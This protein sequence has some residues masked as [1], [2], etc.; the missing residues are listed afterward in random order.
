MTLAKA[1]TAICGTH[2]TSGV[3]QENIDKAYRRTIVVPV[4]AATATNAQGASE[5][6]ITPGVAHRLVAAKY[7][8]NGTTL[9]T[10]AVNSATLELT[11]M[12]TDGSTTTL[13]GSLGNTAAAITN[14]IAKALTM[15]ATAADGNAS[16]SY[17]VRW[18]KGDIT[19]TGLAVSKGTLTL[20]FEEID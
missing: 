19:T 14:A 16:E 13:V 7:L 3:T 9:S 5:S 1:K 12:A 18:V 2:L 8:L 15:I 20:I 4:S 10:A 6:V 17:Y 11:R